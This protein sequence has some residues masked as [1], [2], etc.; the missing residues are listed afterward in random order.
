MLKGCSKRNTSAIGACVQKRHTLANRR[1][2][3]NKREPAAVPVHSTSS[4]EGFLTNI[5]PWPAGKA[6]AGGEAELLR[7]ELRKVR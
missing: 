2:D 6:E 5:L 4:Q 1:Y 7:K 3:E